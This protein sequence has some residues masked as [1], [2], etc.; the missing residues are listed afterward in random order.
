MS[1]NAD[2]SGPSYQCGYPLGQ[3]ESGRDPFAQPAETGAW[4]DGM[5]ASTGA[6]CPKG[7]Q[8]VVG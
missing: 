2:T 1:R 6:S 8:S 4:E 5:A 7:S 3:G